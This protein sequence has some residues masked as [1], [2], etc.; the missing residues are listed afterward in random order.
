MNI[1]DFEKCMINKYDV[2]EQGYYLVSLGNGKKQRGYFEPEHIL[3]PWLVDGWWWTTAMIN[4]VF[5]K[6]EDD[7]AGKCLRP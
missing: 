6:I 5:S 7:N 3:C 4:K 1:G 2:T